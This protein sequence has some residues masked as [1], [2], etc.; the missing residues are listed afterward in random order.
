MISENLTIFQWN[1]RA[2]SRRTDYLKQYLAKEDHHILLLQSLYCSR[3]KLPKL[4][5]YYYPPMIDLSTSEK[6]VNVA[7]Y[8][9]DDLE[10]QFCKSPVPPDSDNVFSTAVTL[11]INQSKHINLA[12]IYYPRG[13]NNLNSNWLKEFDVKN[14]SWVIGGD[15]NCHSKLWDKLSNKTTNKIFCDNVIDSNL[16]LT[17]IR[18]REQTHYHLPG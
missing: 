8:I 3:A 11:K 4:A 2:I 9:R 7:I 12:S 18:K 14:E 6:Y 5:G 16:I 1:C 17:N 15:F 10:Y 13:P